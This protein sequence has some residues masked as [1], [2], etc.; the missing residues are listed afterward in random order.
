MC[1]GTECPWLLYEVEF[2]CLSPEHVIFGWL[3]RTTS[4]DAIGKVGIRVHITAPPRLFQVESSNPLF[5]CSEFNLQS[6]FIMRC[7]MG[8]TMPRSGRWEGSPS[9][10][11][12]ISCQHSSSKMGRRSG[13]TP[14][15]RQE[16]IQLLTERGM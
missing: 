14:G 10:E 12:S 9:Q 5:N 8:W 3:L 6:L 15:K 2:Q 1:I 16:G 13:R 7:S 11:A 4:Q